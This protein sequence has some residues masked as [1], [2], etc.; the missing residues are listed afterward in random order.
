MSFI[1]IEY[2][3]LTI[4]SS[5]LLSLNYFPKKFYRLYQSIKS[6][7][8]IIINGSFLFS[9]TNEAHLCNS[10]MLKKKMSSDF[11]LEEEIPYYKNIEKLFIN[12]KNLYFYINIDNL[13]IENSSTAL[14]NIVYQSNIKTNK[15]IQYRDFVILSLNPVLINISY[16]KTLCTNFV[17][18][19]CINDTGCGGSSYSYLYEKK[20]NQEI[21]TISCIQSL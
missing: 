6:E 8:N 11:S 19:S 13:S 2:D 10:P 7:D 20:F 3:K 16:D 18:I 4:S 15:N 12:Y 21:P 14:D 5:P 17:R 9:E 1:D